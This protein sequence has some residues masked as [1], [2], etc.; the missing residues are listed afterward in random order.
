M[1]TANDTNDAEAEPVIFCDT[2]KEP[3]ICWFPLN[4]FEPVVAY[5]PVLLF[6]EE[7]NEFNCVIDDVTEPVTKYLKSNDD[8]NCD[9]PDIVPAGIAAEELI[10]PNAVICADELTILLPVVSNDEV[11]ASKLSNRVSTDELN[12]DMDVNT[13]LVKCAEDVSRDKVAGPDVAPPLIPTPATTAVI[14]PAPIV[15]NWSSI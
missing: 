7:V 3:V 5:E 9:E 2:T 11:I 12:D 1:L 6:I 15:T 13:P 14:S 10:N 8:V 4:E